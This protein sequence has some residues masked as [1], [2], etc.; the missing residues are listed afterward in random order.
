[1]KL[2][3]TEIF[4]QL[5]QCHEPDGQAQCKSEDVDEGKQFVPGE[6]PPG[7]FAVMKKHKQQIGIIPPMVMPE[8][9]PLTINRLPTSNASQLYESG[10][11][12]CGYR[13]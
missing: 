9:K 11:S 5:D 4:L 6:I 3:I 13:Q 7:Q 1:M 8:V 2:V 12:P 10:Q